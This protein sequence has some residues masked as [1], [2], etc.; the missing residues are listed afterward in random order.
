[1]LKYCNDDDEAMATR[2]S[3][4]QQGIVMARQMEEQ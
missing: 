1:M 3:I 4:I 2:Q